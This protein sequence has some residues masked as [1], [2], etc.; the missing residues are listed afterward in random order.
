MFFARPI[1]QVISQIAVVSLGVCRALTTKTREIGSCEECDA[2]RLERVQHEQDTSTRTRVI[3]VADRSN[4]SCYIGSGAV[5]VLLILSVL[6]LH[7]NLV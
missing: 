4:L 6:G 1:M 7:V 2:R 5:E 3:P